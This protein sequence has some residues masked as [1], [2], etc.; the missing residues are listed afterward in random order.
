MGNRTLNYTKKKLFG[1]WQFDKIDVLVNFN[2]EKFTFFS[3]F[4]VRDKSE[5]IESIHFAG[6][7]GLSC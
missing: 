6:S 2:I 7:S 5:K 4:L 1:T 3:V